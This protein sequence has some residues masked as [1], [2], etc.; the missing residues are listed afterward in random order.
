MP[1]GPEKP[2]V[3]PRQGAWQQGVRRQ[4]AG[5]V[6]TP[7]GPATPQEPA[8]GG[9]TFH[10]LSFRSFRL[11][12]IGTVFG[13]AGMWVQQATLSWIVYDWTGSGT[14]LGA[15]GLA[16]AIP[17]L[18]LQPLAGVATDRMDRKALILGSQ[19]AMLL[20]ALALGIG[21]AFDRVEI[22]H[23]FVFTV[24]SGIA[25]AINMPVRQTVVFDLVPR[26]VVPNAVA[27]NSAGFNFTRALGPSV[28]GYLIVWFGP[29]GNFFVQSAA[30]LGLVVSVMMIAFPPSQ[31]SGAGARVLSNLAEGFAYV[32]HDRIARILVLL[33]LVPP[34]LLI[35]C[36]MT[37]TPMFAEDVYNSGPK[38]LGYLLSA[39]GV[40]GVAGALF[41]A[42]LGRYDRRGLL[43]LGSLFG[44]GVAVM[45]FA[46]APSMY[47]A[48]PLLAGAGFFEMMYMSTNQAVLQLSV[49][50]RM[51]GRVTSILM[52][53]MTLM[54]MSG[55]VA[56]SIA[57]LI[58]APAVTAILAGLSLGVALVITLFVP[59]VRRLRLS[60][61]R[62][63]EVG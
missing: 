33:G 57:D 36:F 40:G 60:Q 38:G 48:L 15:I 13:S 29:A 58:G 30:Y 23:L 53:N 41:T 50:D 2:P 16:R 6:L 45:G 62:P 31:A 34:L 18:L 14:L 49:P 17:M 56:G 26:H 51:R 5:A 52:L 3:E 20:F 28:A 37:L 54:P 59:S 46:F 27:I 44:M 25:Q 7:K 4:R 19:I 21:L 12:W 43:Q 39:V 24:L 61:L 35:P 63:A 42:S 55:Q 47:V 10:A 22:W 32:A 11:L 8:R 9:G 1:I